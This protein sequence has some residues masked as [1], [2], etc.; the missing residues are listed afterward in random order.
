[1]APPAEP[2]GDVTN[3]FESERGCL[4]ELL[5]AV[6]DDEWQL[7]TPCPAWTVLGLGCHLLGADFSLLSRHRDHH[8]GTPA[9]D[10]LTE[11]QFIAWL[12]ELQIEWVRAARRVSPRLLVDL[13]AWTGPQVVEVLEQQDPRSRTAHVS[14]AGPEPVPVWLDQVREL[15]E[16]WV[17]R[18]QL[19]QALGRPADLRPELIGPILDGLR[20]AYPYRL[21]A[22]PA[23]PG[24]TVTVEIA[25]SVSLT[26]HLVAATADWDFAPQPGARRVADLSM[27][28]DQ[29]WRLLTNN[30]AADH[31]ATLELSGDDRIADALLRTRA[32]VGAPK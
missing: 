15:S 9:P 3:L 16:C 18:Q 22:V 28:T 6:S 23:R 31:R 1:M 19:L 13:L 20:W 30:V 21:A 11:A 24:D 25:G 4:L 10:G 5:A 26:W 12:D 2:P 32:I 7:P 14:W 17:H 29:A 27:T 8:V